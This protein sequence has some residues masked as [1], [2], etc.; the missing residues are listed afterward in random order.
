M[1]ERS[2]KTPVST[3]GSQDKESNKNSISWLEKI[4]QALVSEISTT[5]QIVDLL[6]DCY[7]RNV[8][9]DDALYMLE[10]VLK[11]TEMQVREIMIPRSQ[12]VVLKLNDSLEE[13]L[14]TIISSAHSRFPV[15]GEDK[16]DIEGIL[17][18]KDLLPYCLENRKQQLEV[19]DL[20]RPAVIIPESKRLNVLLKDFR[21]YR[22]HIAIVVDEYGGVSGLVTIEDVLEEIVGEIKDEHDV[23]EENNI[24]A[25]AG[26]E[27]NV[28]A[29]TPLDEFNEYFDVDLNDDEFET[30]GGI[31]MKA[32]GHMP[33]VNESIEIP[34]FHIVVVDADERR[35]HQLRIRLI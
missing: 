24:I 17:L 25:I 27:Y 32:F 1:K 30:I 33:V 23:E 9:A 18:A 31:V 14:Q 7:H 21:N 8:I 22:N 34:G 19:R 11:V 10:G 6:R 28:N 3:I 4:G 26:N 12:M 2:I 20:L 35:I 15:I 16:D 13:T 5:D 29:L